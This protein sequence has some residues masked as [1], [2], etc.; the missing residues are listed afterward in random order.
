MV[1]HVVLASLGMEIRQTKSSLHKNAVFSQR[2]CVLFSKDTT[3]SL[4]F[5]SS[6]SVTAAAWTSLS[7]VERR[8]NRR[9]IT[10]QAHD[11]A[12]IRNWTA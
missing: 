11:V 7:V 12:A 6:M 3:E 1:T 2:A 10:N 5:L 4:S 9:V 8:A